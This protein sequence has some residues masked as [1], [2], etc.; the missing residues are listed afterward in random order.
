MA[1]N[2]KRE[3][4]I[5]ADLAIVKAISSIKYTLRAVPA[6][7]D[8]S[9]KFSSA[10]FPACAVVGR[11]PTPLNLH[12]ATRCRIDN[13]TDE[14]KVDVYTYIFQ[15]VEEQVDAD[16]SNYA[17]DIY[18]ALYTDQTR[19]GLVTKSEVSIYEENNYFNPYGAFKI[20]VRHEYVHGTEGI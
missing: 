13:I 4:I 20:T 10:Q 18:A 12:R 15:N 16:I 1:L 19:G 8:L 6:W 14:L 9:T 3:Q 7:Q 2:S 11:M 17:D 5:L